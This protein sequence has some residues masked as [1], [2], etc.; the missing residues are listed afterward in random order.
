M[1]KSKSQR[2]S[3]SIEPENSDPTEKE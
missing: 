2:T 1:D 3:N